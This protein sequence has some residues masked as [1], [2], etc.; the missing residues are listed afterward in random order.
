MKQAFF[1][2]L[3]MERKTMEN[4]LLKG[5][6]LNPQSTDIIAQF[7][8]LAVGAPV[9]DGWRVLSGNERFSEIARVAFRFECEEE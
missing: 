4:F 8:T 3:S 5:D 7:R 6:A 9:P 2:L 1:Y